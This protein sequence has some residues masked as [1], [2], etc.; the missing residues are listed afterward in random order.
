[1]LKLP[2]DSVSKVEVPGGRLAILT[3]VRIKEIV[4]AETAEAII[5]QEAIAVVIA[6]A[7]PDIKMEIV[8]GA[9]AM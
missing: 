2:T 9:I 7:M 5:V 4:G 1:L 6:V 8:T 3:L